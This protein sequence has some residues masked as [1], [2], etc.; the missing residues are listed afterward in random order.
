MRISGVD[1]AGRYFAL[2]GRGL[3]AAPI[4]TRSAYPLQLGLSKSRRP[5]TASPIKT[6]IAGKTTLVQTPPSTHGFLGQLALS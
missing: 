6:V 2:R 5:H 4:L 3:E 1:A